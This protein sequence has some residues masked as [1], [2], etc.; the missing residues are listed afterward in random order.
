VLDDLPLPY[1]F[2][3]RALNAITLMPLREH[4]ERVGIAIY[5]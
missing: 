5:P 1:R 2:D 4:I 3:V